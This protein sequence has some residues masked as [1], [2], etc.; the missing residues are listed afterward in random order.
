M[1]VNIQIDMKTETQIVQALGSML[2]TNEG[3]SDEL[4]NNNELKSGN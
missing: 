3:F 1:G 4:N 2:K